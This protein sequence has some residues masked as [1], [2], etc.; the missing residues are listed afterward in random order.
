MVESFNPS[1]GTYSGR[2]QDGTLLV[3][4]TRQDLRRFNVRPRTSSPAPLNESAAN[5][6]TTIHTS[7][8]AVVSSGEDTTSPTASSADEGASFSTS[9]G[10]T[11][12]SKPTTPVNHGTSSFADSQPA[13]PNTSVMS[14]RPPVAAAA[15]ALTSTSHLAWDPAWWP[16]PILVHN[17][18]AR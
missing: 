10:E 4:L 3:N 16:Q 6:V 17:K 7:G 1:T 5:G 8:V 12:S 9:S 2:F 14:S 13:T 18:K 15:V 11:P